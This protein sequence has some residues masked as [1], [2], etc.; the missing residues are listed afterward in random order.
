M[1][2]AALG[3]GA[4]V[5]AR[6][7]GRHTLVVCGPGQQRRRW[8]GRGAATAPGRASGGLRGLCGLSERAE[9]DAALY[10]GV[11][12]KAGVN[13]RMGDIPAYLWEETQLVVDCLLK[14]YS[15]CFCA[16]LFSLPL[17]QISEKHMKP[18][19]HSMKEL[20]FLSVL[21]IQF[22]CLFADTRQSSH[23][24]KDQGKYLSKA[25]SGKY[26]FGRRP[27]IAE[28]K[29]QKGHVFGTYHPFLREY[30]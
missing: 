4:L 9:P 25:G 19:K 23:P 15:A 7:A 27:E 22:Y 10:Y 8:P 12:E 24:L 16:L 29:Y 1:E 5:Q 11:A 20:F 26:H 2:R 17:Q 13:L 30:Q 18:T 21:T 28:S 14:Y 3:V 6:Y